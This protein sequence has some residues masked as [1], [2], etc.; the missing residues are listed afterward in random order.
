MGPPLCVL[1]TGGAGYIGSHTVL[2]LL[3]EGYKTVVVDNFD[4]SSH[5]AIHRVQ[6]LAGDYG[7]NLSFHKVKILSGPFSNSTFVDNSSRVSSF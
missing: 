4:N 7:R 2:Q 6:K 5:V 1:V 3:L